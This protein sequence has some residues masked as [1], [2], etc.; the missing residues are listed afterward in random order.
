[1]F[2]DP[3]IPFLGLII[4]GNIENLILS[5]HGVVKGANPIKL[6]VMSIICVLLWLFIGTVGTNILIDYADVIELIG[7]VAIIILG[8]QSMIQSLK[9]E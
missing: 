8:L 9:Y 6:G 7:A 4:F 3:Y 1:M 2:L 5:S